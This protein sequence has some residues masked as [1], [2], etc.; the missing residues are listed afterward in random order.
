MKYEQ[1]RE[2]IKDG[3]V[4]AWSHR[5][6]PFASWY[7]FKIW[8]V[9]LFTRSEYSHVGIAL[10]FGGR[11]FVLESVTG[12]IRLMPLSKCLPCYLIQDDHPFGEAEIERIMSVCGEPYS[13][14]EAVLGQLDE[15]DDTNGKWQCSEAVRWAKLLPCKAT[16]SAVV[17]Y[18]LF[19]GATLTEIQP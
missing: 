17:S 2:L 15:T 14:L 10:R 5:A 11:V 16:P 8:L 6:S 7:D 13:E 12:G 9:R 1:A 19:S 18:L 3:D 4:L